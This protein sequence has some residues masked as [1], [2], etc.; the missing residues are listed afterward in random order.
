[1]LPEGEFFIDPWLPVDRAVITHAHS[2]HA[3]RGMR[4]LAHRDSAELLR[5][6]LGADISLQTW[7]M[8]KRLD[9]GVRISLHPAGHVLGSAQV[10]WSERGRY[11]SLRATTSWRMMEHAGLSRRCPAIPSSRNR[12]SASPYTAESASS[13]SFADINDWCSGMRR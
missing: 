7:S 6:R 11:G 10:E 9:N 5:I 2:D 12:P 3:R 4:Y 1:M 8:A 13:R